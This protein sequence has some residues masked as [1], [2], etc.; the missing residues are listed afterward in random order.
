MTMRG[1]PPTAAMTRR[2]KVS[3]ACLIAALLHQDVQHHAVLVHSTPQPVTGDRDPALGQQLL[4]VAQAQWKRK[5]NHAAWL[6]NSI[7]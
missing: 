1:S 2:R 5:Y 3:A 4:D 7:G 6:M